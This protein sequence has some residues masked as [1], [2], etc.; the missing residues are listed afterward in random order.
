MAELI[1]F[2]DRCSS[3]SVVPFDDISVHEERIQ[4]V[5]KYIINYYNQQITLA[6]ISKMAYMSPT[7]FSK[8][9]KK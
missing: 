8:K 3:H 9:F 5:C 6:D 7:Y 1:I 2:L 4:R